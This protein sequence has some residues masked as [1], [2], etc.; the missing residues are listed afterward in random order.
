MTKTP[1][2]PTP[3]RQD[4]IV[5]KDQLPYLVK[6]TPVARWLPVYREFKNQTG[7][8]T[9]IRR[10]EG[11]IQALAKDLAT[12]IPKQ[13]IAIQEMTHQ[14]RIKGN[15]RHDVKTWLISRQF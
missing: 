2:K 4:P 6:R 9:V 11:N 13:R 1:R 8:W 14:I 10:I 5:T 15:Y 12:I 7:I 3:S